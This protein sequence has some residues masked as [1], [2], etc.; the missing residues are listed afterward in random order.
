[1]AAF[2]GIFFFALPFPLIVDCGCTDRLPG[3]P[4]VAATAGLK[5]D[6]Q[7][8][9]RPRRTGGAG[10]RCHVIGLTAVVAGRPRGSRARPDHVLVGIGMFFSNSP[11]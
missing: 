10:H 1:L 6:V 3:R 9:A 7:G 11:W 4:F 8:L 2:I 5:D